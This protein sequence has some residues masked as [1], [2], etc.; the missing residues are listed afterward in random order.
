MKTFK[1]RNPVA[2]AAIMRKGGVHEKTQKAKR[3]AHKQKLS[4][5]I[6]SRNFDS[7]FW[8]KIP[9]QT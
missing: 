1:K 6:K 3:A 2:T 8:L 4:K 9:H 5:N 7:F